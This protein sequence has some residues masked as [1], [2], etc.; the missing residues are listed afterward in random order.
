MTIGVASKGR[1]RVLLVSDDDA[2][3]AALKP[4]LP[5][6]DVLSLTESSVWVANRA[7]LDVTRGIDAV[8]LDHQV[9]GRLQLRLYETLRPSDSVARVPVIFTRSKLTAAT[10]GFD[11]ELDVYQPQEA[12]MDETAR[13]VTHV[14]G[15]SQMPSGVAAQMA[16]PAATRAW[17]GGGVRAGFFQRLVLWGV[18]SALIGFTFW[19]LVGSGPI[20]E[21]VYGPFKALS[22]GAASIANAEANAGAPR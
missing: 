2:F 7:G 1:R 14:L 16:T 4:R 9:T 8:L 6:M 10:G 21:A 18:A 3:S 20:R 17:R 15:A 19:P 11:H 22:G 12:S 13:L 5:G